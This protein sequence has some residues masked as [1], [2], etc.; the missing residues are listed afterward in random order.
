MGT[1]IC[2]FCCHDRSATCR[3]ARVEGSSRCGS[4]GSTRWRRHGTYTLADGRAVQRWRCDECGSTRSDRPSVRPRQRTFFRTVV[5]QFIYL[6][7]PG[8]LRAATRRVEV[9]AATASRW[10]SAV[11][12]GDLRGAMSVGAQGDWSRKRWGLFS[13]ALDTYRRSPD[14]PGSGE[15]DGPAPELLGEH[16]ATVW[17]LIM[18]A[19]AVASVLRAPSR[20]GNRVVGTRGEWEERQAFPSWLDRLEPDPPAVRHFAFSSEWKATRDAVE[21]FGGVVRRAA[22]SRD[23][24]RPPFES[25]ARCWEEPVHRGWLFRR[26]FLRDARRVGKDPWVGGEVRWG[27]RSESIDLWLRSHGVPVGD[28]PVR[29]VSKLERVLDRWRSAVSPPRLKRLDDELE[30]PLRYWVRLK[31]GRCSVAVATRRRVVGT[32]SAELEPHPRGGGPSRVGWFHPRDRVED[33]EKETVTFPVRGWDRPLV[34][35]AEKDA[36]MEKPERT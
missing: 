23:T 27:A 25:F 30:A 33:P 1:G 36:V 15:D 6:G 10:V 19:R 21:G 22:S 12:L 18:E 7:L 13:R 3:E 29:F 32:A 5:S 17:R 31:N 35:E 11:D 28:L 14:P 4:C 16:S 20:A 26:V 9:S 34:L 2:I 8:A 24:A